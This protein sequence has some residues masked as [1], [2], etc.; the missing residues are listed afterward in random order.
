MRCPSCQKAESCCWLQVMVLNAVSTPLPFLPADTEMRVSE[1]VRLRH[2]VLD[3]RYVPRTTTYM[4]PSGTM[5]AH[6]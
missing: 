1:E 2:R 4:T 6:I 5:T 3:L